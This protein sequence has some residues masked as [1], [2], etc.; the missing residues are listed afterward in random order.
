MV[1]LNPSISFITF[2]TIGYLVSEFNALY[3]IDLLTIENDFF[4]NFFYP[5]HFIL[6][7][8]SPIFKVNL[9]YYF[10]TE[11]IL[12]WSLVPLVISSIT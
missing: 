2:F 10:G 4:Y 8:N 6:V 9:L 5:K 11:Y 12:D 1:T 7:F 3:L